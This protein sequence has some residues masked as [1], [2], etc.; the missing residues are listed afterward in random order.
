M[1]PRTIADSPANPMPVRV[2][3]VAGDLLARG[4]L[5]ALLAGRSSLT[6]EGQV[7]PTDDVVE[8]AHVYRAEA[9][10]WDMN[11]GDDDAI[12][13]MGDVS[14]ALPPVVVLLADPAVAGQVWSAGA[15]AILHRDVTPSRL[16]VAVAAAVEGVAVFDEA[17]ADALIRVPERATSLSEPLTPRETEVLLLLG[18]GHPNKAIAGILGVSENTV[19]FHVNAVF[20]KLGAQSRTEA[21]TRAVRLG[22]LPL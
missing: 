4:G 6:V 14:D 10:V 17:F 20:G 21:V 5:A 2:L 19:K 15:K 11:G 8:A 3:V 22:L 18:E 12:E 16:A 1:K 13:R 7:S 9:V